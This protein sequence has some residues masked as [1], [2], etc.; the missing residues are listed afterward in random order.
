MA[1][2]SKFIFGSSKDLSISLASRVSRLSVS[3]KNAVFKVLISRSKAS[4]ERYNS[5]NQRHDKTS[6]QTPAPVNKVV[7]QVPESAVG[8]VSGSS[9]AILEEASNEV[10]GSQQ[11]LP[12]EQSE[13]FKK[14]FKIYLELLA[15]AEKIS[16]HGGLGLD[17]PKEFNN[18]EALM[19]GIDELDEWSACIEQHLISK[20]A[21]E[22][23]DLQVN[24]KN[25][26][27]ELDDLA[28]SQPVSG[29]P[30]KTQVQESKDEASQVQ[31]TVA[32]ART[33]NME[34]SVLWI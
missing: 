31:K 30:F 2:S 17:F 34:R 14:Y 4:T 11:E 10:N 5:A 33:V 23:D 15:S 26:K 16:E 1:F 12:T 20:E 13:K 29:S 21:A 32:R 18:L 24:E 6:D 19:R 9:A 27:A 3:L 25:I 22:K 8:M 7:S 28:K